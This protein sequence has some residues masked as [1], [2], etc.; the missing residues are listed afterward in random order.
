MQKITPYLWFDTEARDAAK[1][2]T[3]I[4]KNSKITS[5]TSMDGTPS[6]TVDMLTIN[7][8][9]QE[10]NMMSAGPYFKINPSVS[11]LVLLPTIEEVD[12]VWGKISENGKVMMEIGKYPYSERYGWV[13]DK[14]GVSW[15]IMFAGK[16]EIRQ[17]VTPTLMFTEDKAG[18]AEE[19]MNFYATVF[20][21]ANVGGIARY[22]K[23]DE[24]DIE[25]TVKHAVFTIEGQEFFA[26][27][28]ARMHGFTFSEAIS[29]LVK[30]KDQAEIDY[31]WGKLSADPK[32]EQCGWLK[33]KYGVSWQI[34]PEAMDQMMATKDKAALKRV[35]ESFLKM[36]KFDLAELQRAYEGK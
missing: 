7:I 1:F 22:E 6:G 30:C 24:P 3:S 14:F 35:T 11:F 2:Y 18:K 32:S 36:K 5:D 9:G 10:I 33:D 17:A 34:V 23:G 21:N 28:S 12:E 16:M 29:F 15:Q 8:M 19:A 31:Y 25:G 26:M 4:F 20:R 13:Q 27:D